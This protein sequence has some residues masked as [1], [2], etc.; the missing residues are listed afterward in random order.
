MNWIFWCGGLLL[1]GVAALSIYYAFKS[2][3]FL[4]MLTGFASR[5]AWKI[6]KPVIVPPLTPDDLEA[7]N[8]AERSANGDNWIRRRLG[9]LR[10]R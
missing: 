9:S 1:F 8:K 6:V 2:P 7:K 3:K 5:Q 10:D 4:A